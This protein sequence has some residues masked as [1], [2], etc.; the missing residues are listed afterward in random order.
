MVGLDAACEAQQSGFEVRKI[1]EAERILARL[2][3][4]SWRFRAAHFR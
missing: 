2:S 1:G 4:N 3:L